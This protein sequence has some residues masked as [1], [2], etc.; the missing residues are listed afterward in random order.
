MRNEIGESGGARQVENGRTEHNG[1]RRQESG[2]EPAAFQRTKIGSVSD[3]EMT[4]FKKNI[5]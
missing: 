5:Q 4:S 1:K 3:L 2:R